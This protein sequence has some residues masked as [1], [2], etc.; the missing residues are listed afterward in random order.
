VLEDLRYQR[1]VDRLDLG[2]ASR[3]AWRLRRQNDEIVEAA[4]RFVDEHKW[5][6]PVVDVAG[7]I[8]AVTAISDHERPRELIAPRAESDLPTV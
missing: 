2:V 4:T 1:F 3:Q 8:Q 6:P 7:V 5:V